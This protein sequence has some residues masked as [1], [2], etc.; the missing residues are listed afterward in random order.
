M[1]VALENYE[2]LCA[3]R[4][5]AIGHWALVGECVWI[6]VVEGGTCGL[7][8]FAGLLGLEV[9]DDP[10]YCLTPCAP[11]S[12]SAWFHWAPAPQMVLSCCCFVG[13]FVLAGPWA[14]F[15]GAFASTSWPMQQ[16]QKC[17]VPFWTAISWPVS[18]L[19]PQKQ[20]I[21]RTL[22]QVCMKLGVWPKMDVGWLWVRHRRGCL[23]LAIGGRI[24]GCE[25]QFQLWC[26]LACD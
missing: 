7:K 10:K 18:C 8:G 19:G 2:L 6:L 9:L 13:L 11:S 21:E 17:R 14:S 5:W 20:K 25:L 12:Y 1:N 23:P 15:E 4:T 26:L 22:S 3:M 16:Y 24:L